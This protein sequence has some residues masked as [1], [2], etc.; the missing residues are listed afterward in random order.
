VN[1][2][3]LKTPEPAKPPISKKLTKE[4][5]VKLSKAYWDRALGLKDVM[6]QN[7]IKAGKSTGHRPIGRQ[8][9]NQKP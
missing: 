8:K 9:G 4:E 3:L 6:P 1:D 2:F 5:R 7:R